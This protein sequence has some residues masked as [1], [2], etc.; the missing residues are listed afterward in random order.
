MATGIRV[1]GVNDA[2]MVVGQDHHLAKHS[3][4]DIDLMVALKAEGLTYL[5]IAVK[6]EC[7]KSAVAD[8][9][10]GRRRGHLVVGQKRLPPPQ[11]RRQFSA[12]HTDE[13]DVVL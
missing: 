8:Y 2:G 4:H 10:K 6:F 1:C 9:C 13:F 7:S 3:D 5:Q 12:A 11:K